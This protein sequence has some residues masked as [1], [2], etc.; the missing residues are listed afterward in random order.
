[1]FSLY[2]PYLLYYRVPDKQDIAF[3]A[4]QQGSMCIDTLGHFSDGTIGLFVCHNT[5]G[6]QVTTQPYPCSS[7]YHAV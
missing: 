1:M 7:S 3:G 2:N 5:G 6:N 4:V